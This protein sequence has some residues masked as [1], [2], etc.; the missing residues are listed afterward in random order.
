MLQQHYSDEI[1][2]RMQESRSEGYM[3]EVKWLEGLSAAV[4]DEEKELNEDRADHL[5]NYGAI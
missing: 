2:R 1:Q 3:E 4:V 5:D